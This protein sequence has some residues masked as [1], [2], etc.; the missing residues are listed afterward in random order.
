MAAR[1]VSLEIEGVWAWER[2]FPQPRGVVWVS[3]QAWPP[4]SLSSPHL[5]SLAPH[6]D[7]S[8][9]GLESFKRM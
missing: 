4:V 7:S 8:G 9:Q 2:F 6:Q 5:L 3:D 1:E